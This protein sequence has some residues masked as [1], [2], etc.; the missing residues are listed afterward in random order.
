MRIFIR[1][2]VNLGSSLEPFKPWRSTPCSSPVG[3]EIPRQRPAAGPSVYTAPKDHMHIQI[4]IGYV[5]YGIG[6]L[7][8]SAWYTNIRIPKHDFCISLVGPWNQTVRS[9]VYVVFWAP[10]FG[11]QQGNGLDLTP[12]CLVCLGRV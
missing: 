11:R 3:F 5:V 12:F 8:Y 10:S 4:L 1:I 9:C 2:Y 7:V 6:Y